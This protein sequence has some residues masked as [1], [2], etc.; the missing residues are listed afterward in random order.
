MAKSLYLRIGL[1][2]DD[3]GYGMWA[4]AYSE[5]EGTHLIEEVWREYRPHC[6]AIGCSADYHYRFIDDAANY[7]GHRT[8][9]IHLLGIEGL[10]INSAVKMGCFKEVDEDKDDSVHRLIASTVSA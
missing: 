1:D 9:S 4:R 3:R 6:G 8:E 7:F 5:Q 10:W 2:M